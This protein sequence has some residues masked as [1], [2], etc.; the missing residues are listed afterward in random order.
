MIVFVSVD[1]DGKPQKVRSWEPVTEKERKL[2]EYAKKLKSLREK[3][4]EEMQPFME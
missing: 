2:A 4:S 1:E 3:I